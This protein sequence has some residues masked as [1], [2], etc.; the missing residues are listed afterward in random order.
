VEWLSARQPGDGPWCLTVG[1]VNPHDQQFF[2]AG[3]EFQTYNNLFAP[4]APLQPILTYSTSPPIVSWDDDPL[5][6]PPSLGYPALPVAGA[7]RALDQAH[8]LDRA[9]FRPKD[10]RANPGQAGMKLWLS[11]V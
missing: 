6:S 1:L 4:G 7:E 2:W 8:R 10:L 9:E 5:K 11:R 3:T